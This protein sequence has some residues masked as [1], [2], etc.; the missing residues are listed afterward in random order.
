M[1]VLVANLTA[2]RIED[3]TPDFKQNL[4][5][6]RRAKS[7]SAECHRLWDEVAKNSIHE[8]S[9]AEKQITE[10]L[11]QDAKGTYAYFIDKDQKRTNQLVDSI[12]GFEKLL[13]QQG[14]NDFRAISLL[15]QIDVCYKELGNTVKSLECTQRINAID[16]KLLESSQSS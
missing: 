2:C 8:L 13:V 3:Y 9:A 12:E 5:V 6:I 1:K 10:G 14:E 7:Y 15:N 16:R 11:I 4:S